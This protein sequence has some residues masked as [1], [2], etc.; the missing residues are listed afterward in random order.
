MNPDHETRIS[1]L[2]RLATEQQRH[3]AE[4]QQALKCHTAKMITFKFSADGCNKA[5]QILWNDDVLSKI[6]Y[7]LDFA[8]GILVEETARE[9]F[10]DRLKKENINFVI[11]E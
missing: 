2:E 4:L 10:S 3:V 11:N 9:V 5:V 6:K 8:D 1:A 7:I